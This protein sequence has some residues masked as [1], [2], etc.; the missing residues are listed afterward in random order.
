MQNEESMSFDIPVEAAEIGI[1]Y[2]EVCQQLVQGRYYA[3]YF[4]LIQMQII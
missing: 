4:V 1:V 2:L 3:V